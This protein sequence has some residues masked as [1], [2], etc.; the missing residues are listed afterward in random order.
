MCM[1]QTK[2]LIIIFSALMLLLAA[3]FVVSLTET[4]AD[5]ATYSGKVTTSTLNVRSGPSTSYAIVGKL[6]LNQSIQVLGSAT[7]GGVKWYRISYN[8]KTAYV[9]ASYVK[10]TS[11]TI[12]YA[13]TR[14]GKL[15]KA[16]YV[17]TGPSTAYASLGTIASG[18]QT[19]LYGFYTNYT[20]TTN[21]NWFRISFNGKTGYVLMD[22]IAI[23]PS[24]TEYT[25]PVMGLTT[26]STV[27]R[28]SPSTTGAVLA[29]VEKNSLVTATAAV[30]SYVGLTGSNWYRLS[31]GDKT[32]Y[33]AATAVRIV[34]TD[35]ATAFE[36]YLTAQGFPESYKTYLRGLHADNPKWI[37]KAQNTGLDWNSVLTKEQKIGTSLLA[38]STAEA[39]KSFEDGAYDFT[40][41]AY[42][43]FDGS[44]NAADSKVVAYYLDPRNFLNE[45]AIYQFM[46]HKFDASSQTT[47]MIRVIAAGSFLDTDAYAA[48]IYKSG[49]AAGVNPNVITSI[50]RQEQ[51]TSGTSGSI[52]GVYPGYEG[53][54]NYFN[55]G[56]Y[57]TSTMT[58][59]Q[60]G[61]WWA[62][63]AGTGETTFGRPWDTREK[64]ITGGALYYKSSYID[65]NQN[66]FYLKKFNVRNG[67]AEVATHQY[68][69]HILAAANEGISLG[70]AYLAYPDN[71]LIFE[72]PIYSNMPA[73]ASAK[74]G[75]TG[76]ND[77]VLNFLRVIDPATEGQYTL[78][79]TGGGT[80][81]SRY[82]T[83]Y[84]ATVPSTVSKIIFNGVAHN[85]VSYVSASSG[86]VTLSA[87]DPSLPVGFQNK[88][89][90]SLTTK[91]IVSSLDIRS[92]AG[93]T[94]GSI[95]SYLSGATVSVLGT[96]NDPA[97]TPWYKVSYGGLT[98]YINSTGTNKITTTRYYSDFLTGTTK[99]SLN[100]RNMASTS[101]T[102][103][104]TLPIG[105]TIP[106]YGY[107]INPDSSKWYM[108]S[109]KGAS[110]TSGEVITLKTG[111]NV[112]TMSVKATSGQTRNYTVTINRN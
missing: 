43:T 78:T 49:Q 15:T 99:V 75:T 89:T 40:K 58:A 92:G 71:A 36:A 69:T 60:R 83:S 46:D 56:A 21:N 8:G 41:N 112:I 59:V 25:M 102:S 101:G 111:V 27:Y 4:Y 106:V 32:A 94:Y 1:K 42:K 90:T 73:T 31:Y 74:P 44:W 19:S 12:A 10:L 100:V 61:L 9:S 23:Q 29:T 3:Y 86:Y 24:V 17:R 53:Y 63:G 48:L 93:I 33:V 50:I 57:T 98:G 109:Y 108:T 72:I 67:L 45:T 18:T 110:V 80:G 81:F 103:L 77:N 7:S 5:T 76:N 84:T 95:G 107:V 85:N 22:S 70:K 65:N 6:T 64:S 13:P 16:T 54:Y 96:V 28:T 26:I 82:V 39:W 34:S 55:V 38:A 87:S 88:G 68:M 104:G 14:I 51:G 2:H 47:A 66:T 37:F 79:R 105:T 30:T 11:Q 52:S 97:G 62:K 20:V 35:D 91:V